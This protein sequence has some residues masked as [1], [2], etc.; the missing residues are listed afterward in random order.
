[1]PP[2][3][4]SALTVEFA[5]SRRTVTA[6]GDGLVFGRGADLD[7]DSNP[8]LHRSVGRLVR[9]DALWWVE[10]L[11][12]W[13][14]LRVTSAGCTALVDY[15]R[16][17]PILHAESIIGFSAGACSYEIRL[18][19]AEPPGPAVIVAQR[20]TD[21]TATF[22]SLDLPLT[23]EQRLMVTVLAEDRLR[24]P[25]RSRQLP[26]NRDGALRLGWSVAK[27]NRKLDWLCHRLDRIGVEGM[28][29]PG[30]RANDRRIHLVNHLVGNGTITVADLA[31]LDA[32]TLDAHT[33]ARSRPGDTDAP[34]GG[35]R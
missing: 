18:H 14:P 19:L 8:F 2:M 9:R 3:S 28:R 15:A 5:G 25:T 35:H 13:T 31:A 10:C 26:S 30:R 6:N 12:E 17:A 27:F 4:A 20:P 34:T 29:S 22:R 7:I 16:S 1:M 23:A 11:G 32:H 21:T 24:E 33:I